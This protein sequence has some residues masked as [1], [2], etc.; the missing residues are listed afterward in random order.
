MGGLW[1]LDGDSP[2]GMAVTKARGG[3]AAVKETDWVATT[4][5]EADSGG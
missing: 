4:L 5:K 3:G 2:K 1:D